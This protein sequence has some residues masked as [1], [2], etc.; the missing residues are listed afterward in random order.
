M[1]SFLR[2]VPPPEKNPGSA[3]VK[4]Y[5]KYEN[6]WQGFCS[7]QKKVTYVQTEC[8]I[9]IF[10]RIMNKH[11]PSVILILLHIWQNWV[12][13]RLFRKEDNIITTYVLKVTVCLQGCLAYK[14][15]SASG[16]SCR[17]LNPYIKLKLLELAIKLFQ[18]NW[19]KM[20]CRIF[21][22]R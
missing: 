6:D 2:G 19:N 12:F 17:Y 4:G 3:P 22:D 21:H 1:T 5:L 10:M 18:E 7:G 13:W 20:N 11:H 15:C 8:R 9:I 14:Q 16:L